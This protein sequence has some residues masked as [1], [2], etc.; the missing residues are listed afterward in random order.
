M[1]GRLIAA[2]CISA[3][4]AG[5]STGP[6]AAKDHT[7]PSPIFEVLDVNKDG[8]V[9]ATEIANAPRALLTL[10]KDGD[11]QLSYDEVRR[12]GEREPEGDPPPLIA[13]LDVNRD[14]VIDSTEIAHAAAALKTLD[15]DGDGR[16]SPAE[17]LPLP[18]IPSRPPVIV[19]PSAHEP[20]T[21][22]RPY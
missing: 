19:P 18:V 7:P 21:R 15:K 10:D 8:V 13:T 22:S 6:D 2:G 14:D 5:C 11:G 3:V 9:D 1:I 12:R 17:V 16:L 4:L 20:G